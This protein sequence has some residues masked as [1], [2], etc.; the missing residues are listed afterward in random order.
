[1]QGERVL[2]EGAIPRKCEDSGAGDSVGEILMWYDER[3]VLDCSVV[4]CKERLCCDDW[5]GIR[6]R[7]GRWEV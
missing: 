3:R 2:R 6:G 1:M 5:S 7:M 4:R